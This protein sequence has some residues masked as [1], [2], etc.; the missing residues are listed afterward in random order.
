[1]TPKDEENTA[2]IV[3]RCLYYYKMMPYGLKNTSVM[4]QRL[5]NK[6]FKQQIGR[7]MKVYIDNILVKSTEANRHITDLQKAFRELHKY[8]MK[9][10]LNK[11]TFGVTSENS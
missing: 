3:E 8:Q 9:L 11:C 1:M 6:V 7:N 10:N 4:Y 5:V 2:F